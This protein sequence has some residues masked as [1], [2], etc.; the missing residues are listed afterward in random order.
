MSMIYKD[1]MGLKV[2]NNFVLGGALQMYSSE[3]KSRK[4]LVVLGR[5]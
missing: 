3:L 4:D 2:S 1:A 5:R